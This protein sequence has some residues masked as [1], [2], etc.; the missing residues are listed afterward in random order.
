MS[1][2][3][4]ITLR[5]YLT[6]EPKFYQKTP[7][8]APVTEIR[9]GCTPRRLNRETGEW[10][11]LPTSYYRVKAW[12]RLAINT[13]SSLHKGDQVLIRGHFYM[14]TWVDNQQ[15]PRST[16]EIEADTIGHDLAYGWSHYLRGT[17]P[18]G[19]GASVNSG[20]VA[21]QDTGTADDAGSGDDEYVSALEATGA[22]ELDEAAPALGDPQ[23][24]APAVWG[25]ADAEQLEAEGSPLEREAVPF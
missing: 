14:S 12:R 19:N 17:R 11:D 6:A 8:A 21:R 4:Q 2:E 5:G 20:E 16:L 25:A 22:D 3:N 9:V 24:A 13:A 15:R 1:Q 7:E 23:P 10:H 18:S